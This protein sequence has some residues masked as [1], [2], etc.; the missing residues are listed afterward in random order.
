MESGGQRRG[1]PVVVLSSFSLL[2]P[3]SETLLGKSTENLRSLM[4]PTHSDLPACVGEDACV[5]EEGD[6]LNESVP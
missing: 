3:Y 6:G 4:V 5:G 2:E 1:T